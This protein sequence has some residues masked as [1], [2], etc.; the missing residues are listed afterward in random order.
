[1]TKEQAEFF[2]TITAYCGNQDIDVRNNYSGRGMF[3]KSTYGVVVSDIT[4]LLADCLNYLRDNN[5]LAGIPDFQGFSMDNM[6]R[7]II[8][9]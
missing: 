7:D 1:M 2:E 9:Y 4:I 6:G 8:L 5:Y 3:G